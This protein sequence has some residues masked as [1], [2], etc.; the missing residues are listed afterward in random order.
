MRKSTPVGAFV[1]VTKSRSW[2]VFV[3]AMVSV[4]LF[5]KRSGSSGEAPLIVVVA[6]APKS[7]RKVC[8][9]ASEATLSMRATAKEPAMARC[10]WDGSFRMGVHHFWS[11]MEHGQAD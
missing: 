8:A 2:P 1:E 4:I 3:P 9:E 7:K 10:E 6:E 5:Q 11:A